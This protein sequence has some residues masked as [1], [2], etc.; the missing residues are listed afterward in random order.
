VKWRIV[1]RISSP[2]GSEAMRPD[3]S[4]HWAGVVLAVAVLLPLAAKAGDDKIVQMF[5]GRKLSDW[6]QEAK[7]PDPIVR[8]DAVAGL[9]R[10]ALAGKAGA[11][12]A[13]EPL[14]A[15]LR[16]E[17]QSIRTDAAASLFLMGEF[18]ARSVAELLKDPDP[19]VRSQASGILLLIGEPALPPLLCLL[20]SSNP[21]TRAQAI[22]TVWLIGPLP[23]MADALTGLLEDES[24]DVREAAKYALQR[25]AERKKKSE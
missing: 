10:L 5:E 12:L 3:I 7:D 20:G 25:L 11:S 4:S 1:E 18:A 13:R 9:G 23:G 19:E 14:L 22:L 16:D 24:P 15:A 21:R 6:I 17:E 8:K 2:E